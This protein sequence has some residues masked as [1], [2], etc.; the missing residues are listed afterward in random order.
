MMMN[1]A[2]GHKMLCDGR[3]ALTR[4]KDNAFDV[5]DP[6]RYITVSSAELATLLSLLPYVP[7]FAFSRGRIFDGDRRC[8]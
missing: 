5:A 4:H 2:L 6:P 1:A 3:F 8:A 7:T